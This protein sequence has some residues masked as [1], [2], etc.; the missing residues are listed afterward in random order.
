[1]T[2]LQANFQTTTVQRGTAQ[3]DF[4]N[5]PG[6]DQTETVVS[7]QL[8]TVNSVIKVWMSSSSTSDH[9]IDEHI[10][11][12]NF[13]TFGIKDVV[14]GFSFTIVAVSQIKLTGKF[15]VQWEWT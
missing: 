2:F 12:G 15:I 13:V 4:G 6:N 14:A 11:A 7:G 8:V 10:I 1:V 5:A 9:T 3:I